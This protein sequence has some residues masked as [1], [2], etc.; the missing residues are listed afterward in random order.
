[1]R[2]A[3]YSCSLAIGMPLYK[4]NRRVGGAVIRKENGAARRGGPAV[5]RLGAKGSK[6]RDTNG[7]FALTTVVFGFVGVLLLIHP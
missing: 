3:V 4:V 5:L 1:M 6:F 7:D 2:A